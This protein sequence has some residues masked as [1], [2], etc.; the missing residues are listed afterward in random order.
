MSCSRR[1]HLS[2]DQAR[3]LERLAAAEG[4]PL[5]DLLR[6]AVDLVLD[7]ARETDLRERTERALAVVGRYRSGLDSV[8]ER[9]DEHLDDLYAN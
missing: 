9:H 1:I 4:R 6:E 2:A 8:A 3:R 7:R 5:A